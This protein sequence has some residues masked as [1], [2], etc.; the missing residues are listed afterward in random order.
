MSS[1]NNYP[2]WESSVDVGKGKWVKCLVFITMNGDLSVWFKEL[3]DSKWR[4]EMY[5]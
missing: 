4:P 5:I 3:Y 1:N 2:K